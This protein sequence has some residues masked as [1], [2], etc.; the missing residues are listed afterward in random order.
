MKLIGFLLVLTVTQSCAM[1]FPQR[2]FEEEMDRQSEGMWVAGQ[3][4]EVTAGDNGQ[5]YRDHNEIMKRT[6]ASN[7]E[8]GET[9]ESLALKEELARYENRLTEAQFKQYLQD[10]DYLHSVSEKIYYLRL[11]ASQRPSYMTSKKGS[12]LSDSRRPYSG[13][14]RSYGSISKAYD[15]YNPVNIWNLEKEIHQGMTKND[16]R[17]V[18]GGPDRVDVAGNPT[19]ENERWIYRANGKVNYVY[20][21]RGQVSGWVLN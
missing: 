20:F 5:I 14:T 6:P 4:F 1:L 2:S 10:Q 8:A 7:F 11:P 9:R 3:D 16:V 13:S 21:E 19:Y 12:S 15:E 17:N 18:L